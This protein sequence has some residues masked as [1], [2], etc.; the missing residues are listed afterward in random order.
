MNLR[1]VGL[2]ALA[3]LVASHAGAVASDAAKMP[4][5]LRDHGG[6]IV[7][8][9]YSPDGKLVITGS[10]DQT[11]RVSE[12]A[13]GKL[14]RK[15][16]TDDEVHR[17]AVSSNGRL[18]AAGTGGFKGRPLSGKVFVWDLA[19][20]KELFKFTG[21]A[22]EINC[23]TFSPDSQRLASNCS[24]YL[25]IFDL[26][27]Q[28]KEILSV[29]DEAVRAVNS[30]AYSPDGKILAMGCG[31]Q[32]VRLWN[33]ATGEP[34]HIFKGH[35][36][37]VNR[38]AYSVDGKRVVSCA[39][40]FLDGRRVGEIKVW[41]ADSGKEILSFVVVGGAI[42]GMALSAD[43]K[44]LAIAKNRFKK[45][46]HYEAGDVCLFDMVTGKQ[47]QSWTAHTDRIYAL[48]FRPDGTQIATCG[49]LEAKLW[50]LKK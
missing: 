49:P 2:S 43:G 3:L 19:S 36:A 48:T 17:L 38:V 41:A 40:D 24:R 7:C 18:L 23:L 33:A 35:T 39:A 8:V 1:N 31:D 9:A 44:L 22:F 47:L 11:V 16:E 50:S 26:A 37:H 42:H 12:A 45:N 25:K 15:M 28:G 10:H 20:G 27:Q 29:R 6:P 13:T 46:G 21:H 34:V 30:L 32:T 14:V 4:L 5:T